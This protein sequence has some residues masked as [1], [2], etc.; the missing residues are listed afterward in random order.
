MDNTTMILASVCAIS[1]ILTIATAVL[2]NRKI[3]K[4]SIEIQKINEL[5]DGWESPYT[6]VKIWEKVNING[7]PI[8]YIDKASNGVV[9]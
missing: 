7:G 9:E 6:H 5:L 1:S 3:R 2:S 8:K 4:Q